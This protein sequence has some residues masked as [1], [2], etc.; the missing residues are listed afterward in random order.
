MGDTA[1]D[2]PGDHFQ[3]QLGSASS[4]HPELTSLETI[5]KMLLTYLK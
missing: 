1:V 2:H 5:W 4:H 3:E